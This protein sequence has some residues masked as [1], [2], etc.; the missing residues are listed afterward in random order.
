MGVADHH[1]VQ[2]RERDVELQVR[3]RPW[4]GVHPGGKPARLEQV[5]AAATA[6]PWVAAVGPEH[7]QGEACQSSVEHCPLGP[8]H[9]QRFGRAH[10]FGRAPLGHGRRTGARRLPVVRFVELGAEQVLSHP[11]KAPASPEEIQR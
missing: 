1:C 7:R 8:L 2:V 5:T 11:D 9:P 4:P 6:R 3:H 10:L